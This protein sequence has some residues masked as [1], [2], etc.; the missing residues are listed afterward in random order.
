[1]SLPERFTLELSGAYARG[2][3]IE[4]DDGRSDLEGFTDTQ[5]RLA[6][7]FG[8]DRLTVALIGLIPTGHS[9]H[10]EEEARVADAMSADLLPF[11]VGNWGT[12]GG[13]GFSVAYAVKTGG[14]GLGAS[15][16][17]VFAGDFEPFDQADAL[18]YHPGDETTLR[19]AVDRTVGRGGKAAL[20]GTWQ[21][22]DDDRLAGANLYRAGDRLQLIGSYQTT[23]GRSTALGYAGLLHR[24]HG[25]SFDDVAPGTPVQDLWLWGAG[26]RTPLGRRASFTPSVEGRVFRNE[27]GEGQGWYAGAGTSFEAPIG[28]LVL[29]PSLRGRLGNVVVAEGSESRIMGGEVGLTLRVPLR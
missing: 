25:T 9:R 17:H 29:I 26:L 18:V 15:A 28:R 13:L 11:R 16:G 12:G 5:L 24:E 6:R 21:H 7:T 27:D 14:F 2:V 23:L 3:V 20:Q 1:V 22:Y 19:L 4:R 10:T 8:R